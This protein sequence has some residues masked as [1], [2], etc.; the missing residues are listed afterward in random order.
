[1]VNLLA[2]KMRALR[3]GLGMSSSPDE[4]SDIRSATPSESVVKNCR[5]V[6]CAIPIRSLRTK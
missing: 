1:M 4:R 2:Q 5:V 6:I 3:P